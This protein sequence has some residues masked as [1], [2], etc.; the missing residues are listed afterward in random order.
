MTCKEKLAV[1]HPDCL[2]HIYLAG[3]KGCPDTYGYLPKPEGCAND[4]HYGCEK[5][6]GREIPET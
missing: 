3:C 4:I 2:D 5:C 6:W 1:E